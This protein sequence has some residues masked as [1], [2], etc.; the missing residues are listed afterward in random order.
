M[1][2]AFEA[3]A[4]DS[5]SS[6]DG[7]SPIRD[8]A[9][10]IE[11]LPSLQENSDAH[12]DHD[13]LLGF[14]GIAASPPPQL[15]P[16]LRPQLLSPQQQFDAQAV[17]ERQAPALRQPKFGEAC[18]EKP[19]VVQEVEPAERS[20]IQVSAQE[21]QGSDSPCMRPLQRRLLLLQQQQ[22][23]ARQR[24]ALALEQAEAHLRLREDPPPADLASTPAAGEPEAGCF[25]API[26][27]RFAASPAPASAS[28]RAVS[29]VAKACDLAAPLEAFEAEFDTTEGALADA[30]A[31][32]FAAS[33]LERR[34]AS[35][36]EVRAH[37]GAESGFEARDDLLRLC[38]LRHPNVLQL[39]RLFFD[40][41][42][43]LAVSPRSEASLPLLQGAANVIGTLGDE[44]CANVVRQLLSGLTCCHSRGVFN[45]WLG[46]EE[47]VLLLPPAGP[48]ASARIMITDIG[49]Q[50][51]LP[52]KAGAASAEWGREPTWS[53]PVAAAFAWGTQ[54]G[55]NFTVAKLLTAAPEVFSECGLGEAVDLWSV[56]VLAFVLASGR[57]PFEGQRAWTQAAP[58][59]LRKA[60]GAEPAWC[61][62]GE[63]LASD[64]CRQLLC[65][66]P[67]ERPPAA[68]ASRHPWLTQP[69]RTAG[70]VD[71]RAAALRREA[72]S[73]DL[74]R[75]ASALVA[76]QLVR[77]GALQRLV[78]ALESCDSEC[79]RPED[80]RRHGIAASERCRQ[81]PREAFER[82]LGRVGVSPAA[83][84][85]AAAAF[86]A[87]PTGHVAHVEL[88]REVGAAG[89]AASAWWR[90]LLRT[91]AFASGD[92]DDGD[93][94]IVVWTRVPTAKT[95]EAPPSAKL[96]TPL[97]GLAHERVVTAGGPREAA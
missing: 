69:A 4:K 82:A 34:S 30:A 35:W 25:R 9:V 13:T 77:R 50:H 41:R 38:S 31:A 64:F 51:A 90:P 5:A 15:R 80:V 6:R 49:L 32:G 87:S 36:F 26:A 27:S 83:I 8:R 44:L 68:E 42:G 48:S 91:E 59:E 43:L 97:S 16:H 60:H 70:R 81:M 76:G 23:A 63:G 12:V 95:Q 78:M 37:R 89:H 62:L 94:S 21:R 45:L 33:C 61:E 7:I 65:L 11:D 73:L 57:W 54:R 40:S 2:S 52:A 72:D 66:E 74:R 22:D 19:S 1:F 55:R 3:W 71:G 29:L 18:V 96:S 67:A 56:G 47:G 17:D 20:S 86:A 93:G 24:Q 88:A 46:P 28:N 92:G 75:R 79:R 84:G 39:E 53:S 10:S 85:C 58:E 14:F